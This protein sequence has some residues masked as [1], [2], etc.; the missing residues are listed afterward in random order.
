[1]GFKP[2]TFR[3]RV[4]QS[5]RYTSGLIDEK[6]LKENFIHMLYTCL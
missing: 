4:L 3:S 1:M 5:T 2:I 6:C